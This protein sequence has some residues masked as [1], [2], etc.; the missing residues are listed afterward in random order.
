MPPLVGQVALG[1]YALLLVVG[2]VIGFVKAGSRPSLIAGVGSGVVALVALAVST[3][4]PAVGFGIGLATALVVGVQ[5]GNRYRRTGKFM[6]P[7]LVAL[8]SVGVAILMGLLIGFRPG[9]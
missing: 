2:G 1:I 5:M 7:G 6:P 3:R 9:S 4:N 8:V